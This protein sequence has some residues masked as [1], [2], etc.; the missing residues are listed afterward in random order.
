M[1]NNIYN[2]K[3]ALL[4]LKPKYNWFIYIS[5]LIFLILVGLSII[6]KTYDTFKVQGIYLE[7]KIIL[8]VSPEE[9]K[10]ILDSDYMCVDNKK[11]KFSVL[12]VSEIEI[13]E[14]TYTNYQTI[15]LSTSNNYIDNLSLDITFYKNKQR[16][17]VKLFNFLK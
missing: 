6:I 13:D 1:N 16:I 9:T 5:I 3:Y 11:N 10:K 15:I 17:I 14:Y 4:N 7:E 2:N 12:S 8:R